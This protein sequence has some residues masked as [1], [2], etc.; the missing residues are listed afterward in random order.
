MLLQ[1]GS[2]L[3]TAAA[4]MQR[5]RGSLG[6]LAPCCFVAAAFTADDPMN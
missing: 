1:L 4:A 3:A 2:V 5:R 6:R